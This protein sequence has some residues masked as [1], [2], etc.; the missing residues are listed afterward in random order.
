MLAGEELRHSG[1]FGVGQI[2]LCQI[3]FQAELENQHL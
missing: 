3:N 2:T 1:W